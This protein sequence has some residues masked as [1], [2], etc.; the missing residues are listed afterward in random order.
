MVKK[1]ATGSKDLALAS[2]AKQRLERDRDTVAIL[3]ERYIYFTADVNE[4]LS[5][6]FYLM[7]DFHTVPIKKEE[8]LGEIEDVP[9]AAPPL[10]SLQAPQ[11]TQRHKTTSNEFPLIRPPSTVK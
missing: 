4:I 11:N 2:G 8:L 1:F 7:I 5:G 9:R 6:L 10:G 3:R